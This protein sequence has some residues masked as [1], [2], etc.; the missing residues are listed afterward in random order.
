MLRGRRGYREW[1]WGLSTAGYWWDTAVLPRV[2]Q[3]LWVRPEIHWAKC[4]VSDVYGKSTRNRQIENDP[5]PRYIFFLHPA[6]QELPL[7][8]LLPDGSVGCSFVL[9]MKKV[10]NCSPFPRHLVLHTFFMFLLSF[11]RW[12]PSVYW[13]FHTWAIP[14]FSLLLPF[15]YL[16]HF[17][18]SVLKWRTR[19]G[20][21]IQHT[22]CSSGNSRRYLL[23]CWALSSHVQSFASPCDI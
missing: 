19:T 1:R 16:F 22:C 4:P 3:Q 2:K 6:V 21:I 14:D 20:W 10:N 17:H 9:V 7:M 8:Y 11:P 13:I 15:F 12:R 5:A 18:Y 23:C